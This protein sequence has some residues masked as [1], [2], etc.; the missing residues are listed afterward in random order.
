MDTFTQTIESTI[1]FATIAKASILMATWPLQRYVIMNQTRTVQTKT[2]P[3]RSFISYSIKSLS[4]EKNGYFRGS[5]ASLSYYFGSNVLKGIIYPA[6]FRSVF[7]KQPNSYEE[8]V[9]KENIVIALAH[10]FCGV[11][12][13]PL[14]RARTLVSCEIAHKN[15]TLTYKNS[16]NCLTKMY[17][18]DGFKGLYRG[19]WLGFSH[20]TLSVWVTHYLKYYLSVKNPFDDFLTK[21]F[22]FV[23]TNAVGAIVAY[24][25][26]VLTR[27]RQL[28]DGK[29][30]NDEPLKVMQQISK[31]WKEE[32]FRGFYR[33]IWMAGINGMIF[34]SILVS[35]SL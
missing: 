16:L 27:R 17:D 12:L 22:A 19:F 35:L 9:I 23:A 29:T 21:M 10:F 31:I 26:L 32:G 14:D 1:S 5:F 15:Q 6:L 18:M 11:G 25:L 24:P 4:I 7:Y 33:G 34:T 13:Y 8:Y 20:F 3:Y 2:L 30:F 28:S